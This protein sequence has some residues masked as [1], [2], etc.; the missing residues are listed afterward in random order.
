MVFVEPSTIELTT[1]SNCQ[2]ELFKP[3]P[4]NSEMLGKRFQSAKTS[5]MI[6]MT[7]IPA[8]LTFNSDQVQLGAVKRLCLPPFQH[9]TTSLPSSPTT[10]DVLMITALARVFKCPWLE[11]A[12]LLKITHDPAQKLVLLSTGNRQWM[13]NANQAA[14]ET[15]DI[16]NVDI[17]APPAS[18][19]LPLPFC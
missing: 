3:R 4:S 9:V 17:T 11:S 2:T 7:S 19:S 12:A 8:T 1:I 18:H 13:S 5:L 14:Q 16:S 6:P 10:I 15:C